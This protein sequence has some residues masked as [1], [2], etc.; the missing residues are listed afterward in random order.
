MVGKVSSWSR[1]RRFMA[2]AQEPCVHD[3]SGEEERSLERTDAVKLP[4]EKK[5]HFVT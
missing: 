4:K 5:M 2:L 3:C 1:D